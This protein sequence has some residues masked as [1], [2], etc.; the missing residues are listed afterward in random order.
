MATKW[1]LESPDPEYYSRED[2]RLQNIINEVTAQK[3]V[4]I[5]T[6]TTGLI[7][8]KD[9]PLFWSLSWGE[10]R[11]FLEANTL[12]FFEDAFRDTNK[13]WELA[14]AKFDMHMLANVG[15]QL[16]GR[17]YD[18]AVMHS[19]LYDDRNHG[20]KDMAAEVL[21]WKWSDFLDTF[22]PPPGVKKADMDVGDMMLRVW[23]SDQRSK[24]I[25]YASNDAYGTRKIAEK[26][27][28]E[29]KEQ[30]TWS[31][32]P[33]KFETMWDI[34]DKIEA[35]FTE[36]LWDCERAGVLVDEEYLHTRRTEI[37]KE[38]GQVERQ[39]TKVI[40]RPIN[41]KSNKQL[42]EYFFDEL[43]LQ[44][45]KFTKGGARS[46]DYDF[47]DH[48]SDKVPAAALMLRHRDLVKTKDTYIE[49]VLSR[50]DPWKRL[51]TRFNQTDVRTGRL[52]SRDPNMQNW[53]KLE[54]D[55][56][57][58][59]R[60]I[61][62]PKDK[63]LIVND[64]EALEMRLLAAA[65]MEKDM[66]D[67]FLRGWDIH[68]GNASLMYGIPYEDIV[69]AK[70]IAK[71][72]EVAEEKAKNGECSEAEL[73]AA[74]AQMTEYVARCVSSRSDAKNIGF[75]LNYGMKA[76]KLARSL[77]CTEQ[78]AE[79]KMQAYKSRYPAVTQFY[80]KAIND[81]RQTGFAFTVL[82][83]R[84][85]LPAIQSRNS[86]DRWQAERQAVNTVIQ[87][88]AA[89]VVKMAMILCHQSGMKRRYGLQMNL[90]VHDELMF[91]CPKETIEEAMM[92]IQD[93]MEH[94]FPTDLAVP[95]TTSKGKGDSW[96]SA[97]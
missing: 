58:M 18:I 29:L 61:I 95:L 81:C 10:R 79:Q 71:S 40:G 31:L 20:L 70:K 47:L 26:L 72:V 4:A 60:G 50:L 85:F 80:D 37:E 73:A 28:K 90:Q 86:G 97:K 83:R 89:D 76:K 8:W 17:I 33:D 15:V 44:P 11:V 75:G 78:Q 42:Q 66:I 45:V 57:K 51:H 30:F 1:N 43:K 55:E 16:R 27:R 68:M 62:C 14:N 84:R 38:L 6:E 59:R 32:Y 41:L 94:P 22:K 88:S 65:A 93:Y 69:K 67:I 91:E 77:K 5:D 82:G 74:Q 53:P 46:V 49:G 36:V 3:Q 13:E 54:N 21:G 48:Y 63:L 64:Y 56:F 96:A 52:S 19:L 2:P 34:F 12:P 7:L 35:P 25:D 39:L 24:L 92:E 9:K 23:N 87:G